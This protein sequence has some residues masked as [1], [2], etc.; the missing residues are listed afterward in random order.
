M[1]KALFNYLLRR[2]NTPQQD[3]S[4]RDRQIAADKKR[5][6]RNQEELARRIGNIPGVRI[7]GISREEA[8]RLQAEDRWTQWYP[9]TS[10][11]IDRIRYWQTRQQL[12]MVTKKGRM[13]QYEGVEPLIFDRFLTAKSPGQFQWYVIRAYGYAY[14]QISEGNSVSAARDD[15]HAGEPFAVS[16]EIEEF[17]RRQGRSSVDRVPM[18]RGVVP[19]PPSFWS[20]FRTPGPGRP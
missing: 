1:F 19:P 16:Q 12:Q 14:R 5:I 18:A 20:Q 3:A 4:E 11:N 10:S 7:P 13:Y 8:A 15:I 17:Q 9:L 6:Q 2:K